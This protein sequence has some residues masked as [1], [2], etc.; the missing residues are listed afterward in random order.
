MQLLTHHLWHARLLWINDLTYFDLWRLQ[1]PSINSS[2]PQASVVH[3]P[4]DFIY[5]VKLSVF[6]EFVYIGE[7]FPS[8]TACVR[9]WV[10]YMVVD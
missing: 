8:P 9:V 1:G 6:L 3:K 5:T 2:P 4:T 7:F 10:K